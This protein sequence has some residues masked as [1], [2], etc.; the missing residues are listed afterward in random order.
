MRYDINIPCKAVIF[1]TSINVNFELVPLLKG[2]KIGKISTDMFELQ[3]FEL[4][5]ISQINKHHRGQRLVVGDEWEMP[6]EWPAEEI[7]GMEGYRFV[8]SL[9]IPMNLRECIQDVEAKGIRIKHK[10]TFVVRLINP[11]S[12]VSEVS[13][14]IPTNRDIADRPSSVQPS[15]S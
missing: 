12:H 10:L 8:R 7:D 11:D 2:L 6:D 3:D 14:A 1:G 4:D 9:K 5:Q 13:Q 15:Q